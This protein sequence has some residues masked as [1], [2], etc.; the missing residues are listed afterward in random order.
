[1]AAKKFTGHPPTGVL[2]V[3]EIQP[4]GLVGNY[5]FT[6]PKDS[7]TLYTFSDYGPGAIFVVTRMKDGRF[8]DG[9]KFPVA[10]IR[11][12]THTFTTVLGASRTIQKWKDIELVLDERFPETIAP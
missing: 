7:L 10:I 6:H 5:G 4:G 12:G 3:T 11:D 1:M 8:V 2:K 9:Q